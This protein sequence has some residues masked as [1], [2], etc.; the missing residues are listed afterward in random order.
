M[1]FRHRQTNRQTDTDTVKHKR[2]MYI[3]HLALKNVVSF[4]EESLY[5]LTI[6]TTTVKS[7]FMFEE[8]VQAEKCPFALFR[9]FVND[10]NLVQSYTIVY[11]GSD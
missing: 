9:L 7:Y 10:G 5:V 2:E 6:L 3:L 11:Y 4:R 1:H 8:N